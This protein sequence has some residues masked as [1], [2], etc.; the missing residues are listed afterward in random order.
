MQNDQ[1]HIMST[2]AAL[3]YGEQKRPSQGPCSYLSKHGGVLAEGEGNGWRD[4]DLEVEG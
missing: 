2:L 4:G 3:P 1:V